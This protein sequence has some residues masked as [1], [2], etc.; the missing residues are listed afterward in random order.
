MTGKNVM[1]SLSKTR[2][3]SGISLS[4]PSYSLQTLRISP[5][6]NPLKKKSESKVLISSPHELETKPWPRDMHAGTW[7]HARN[8]WRGTWKFGR[9]GES[10]FPRKTHCV[11]RQIS[12]QCIHYRAIDFAFAIELFTLLWR[13]GNWMGKKTKGRWLFVRPVACNQMHLIYVNSSRR[14]VQMD[15]SWT[16]RNSCKNLYGS[17]WESSSSHQKRSSATPP[18]SDRKLKIV[19]FLNPSMP[20]CFFSTHALSNIHHQQFL[21]LGLGTCFLGFLMCPSAGT[22]WKFRKLT[23][24]PITASQ[25]GKASCCFFRGRSQVCDSIDVIFLPYAVKRVLRLAFNECILLDCRKSW[26]KIVGIWAWGHLLS[27][28]RI[29]LYG[30]NGILPL[31]NQPLFLKTCGRN[32]L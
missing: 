30:G 20:K 26:N 25:R 32:Y 14:G 29:F 10:L 27:S 15:W 16:L 8:A 22:Y 1:A 28:H 19:R 7:T 3:N 23:V 24:C 12:P 5:L 13:G 21:D 17:L 6:E 2:Q 9:W 31:E 18:K 4:S 11:E